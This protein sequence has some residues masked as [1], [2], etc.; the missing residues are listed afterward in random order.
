MTTLSDL[1]QAAHPIQVAARRTGLSTYVLR[2]WEQ[3]YA[4]VTPQRSASGRRRYS[5]ADIERLQLLQFATRPDALAI[6]PI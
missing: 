6:S 5:D 3:R 2:A 1:K 4:L